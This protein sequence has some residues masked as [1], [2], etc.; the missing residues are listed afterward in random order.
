MLHGLVESL[1]HQIQATLL[2]DF[3]VVRAPLLGSETSLLSYLNG[4]VVLSNLLRVAC[5]RLLRDLFG[6]A[7]FLDQTLRASLVALHRPQ[8]DPLLWQLSLDW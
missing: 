1:V 4:L 6:G 2:S 7:A 5:E 8:H 3:A